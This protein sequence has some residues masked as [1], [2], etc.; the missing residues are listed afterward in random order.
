MKIYS[1]KLVI[2]KKVVYDFRIFRTMRSIEISITNGTT[3]LNNALNDQVHLRDAID[4]F[5]KS[6]RAK[7]KNANELLIRRQRIINAFMSAIFPMRTVNVDDSD[8]DHFI[9]DKL[10]ILKKHQHQEHQ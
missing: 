9:Y 1:T 3:T 8:Y 4:N 2:P 5:K 7:L 10:R 6:M